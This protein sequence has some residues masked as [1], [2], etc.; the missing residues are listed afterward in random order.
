MG[1][2]KH[3][4][5]KKHRSK[6]EHKKR[7][8][9]DTGS[10]SDGDEWVEKT[11]V[12]S[13]ASMT[14]PAYKP[15]PLRDDWMVRP[16]ANPLELTKPVV[17][18]EASP[19]K[20]PTYAQRKELNPFFANDGDGLPSE[21]SAA[22]RRK[23][24]YGDA[25]SGWRMM[26]LDR[27]SAIAKEDGRSL[28]EVALERYGVM[29]EYEEALAERAYL[30][31]RRSGRSFHGGDHG[32]SHRQ[33]RAAFVT[34]GYGENFKKPGDERS[35]SSQSDSSRLRSFMSPNGEGD[36]VDVDDYDR[37]RR[38]TAPT[39]DDRL[40]KKIVPVVLTA[41][42][43]GSKNAIA[44]NGRVLSR[45]ELNT[46]NAKVLKAT[47]M[48][49]EEAAQMGEDYEREK[50]RY[51]TSNRGEDLAVIPNIDSGSKPRDTGAGNSRLQPGARR[52]KEK[53]VMHDRSG[54]RIRFFVDDD[55][56]SLSDM[57]L[58]E[59]T[60]SMSYDK[61]MADRI[62]SDAQFKNDLDY[63]DDSLD[64]AAKRSEPTDARKRSMAI[65]DFQKT[66]TAQERCWYCLQDHRTP[67]VP[68]IAV[69]NKTYLALPATVQM[70]SGHCLIVPAQ[71]CLTTLE[72]EDDVWEEIKNFMKCLIQM[73]AKENK[74]AIFMEQ[75]INFKWQRHTVIECVP[76]PAD[77]Y[78]DAPA[79][80]KE[81]IMTA[82]EEWSQ[83][84]KL[85]DTSKY[86]FRRSMVKNLPYFHVWFDPNKGYGHVIESGKWPEWF[87][88]SVLAGTMLDLPPDKWR[89]PKKMDR[90][91]M[92]AAKTKKSNETYQT[93]QRLEIE[94]CQSYHHP[95]ML[96]ITSFL[97]IGTMMMMM[98]LQTFVSSAPTGTGTN[99]VNT[100][101]NEIQP[102]MV[103]DYNVYANDDVN[104]DEAYP[105]EVY[106]DEVDPAQFYP[107]GGWYGRR[108]WRYGR[109]WSGRRYW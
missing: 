75:V 26:K 34:L 48:G 36:S 69:A 50:E 44:Q 90:N 92:P 73:F 61:T 82:D 79:F 54:Q 62:V 87:G 13:D 59:K 96:Q 10:A 40:V 14:K 12:Q 109:W 30:D 94:K 97:L 15:P 37:T 65:L 105:E 18:K 95:E 23:Y 72:C 101:N 107:G 27:V 8:H 106:G 74:A 24:E 76:I 108:Y 104:D 1:S 33:P 28:E 38:S 57:V 32:K 43:I 83:H 17:E 58:K 84:K 22:K 78:D 25:G 9:S 11:A 67:R 77:S 99:S 39:P 29:A 42:T 47:L 55:D 98:H 6:K 49:L 85:I 52:K 7:K 45:N 93:N 91:D 71:H 46:L 3:R 102:D 20:D 16:P 5:E 68:V 51:E 103:D 66:Q 63:M 88:K 70:V 53:V 81:A 21:E 60:T 64:N 56:D 86:G 35:F 41:H 31:E 80:F 4:K 89:K 2:K 100:P 19:A